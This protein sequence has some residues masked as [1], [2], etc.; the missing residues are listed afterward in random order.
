M[1]AKLIQSW[2]ENATNWSPEQKAAIRFA[3]QADG[4]ESLYCVHPKGTVMDGA[5]AEML[6][7]IGVA[8]KIEDEQ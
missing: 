6:I 8:K 4:D 7:A 1:R 2:E 5:K 3:K